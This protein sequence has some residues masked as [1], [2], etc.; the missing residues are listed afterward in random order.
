MRPDTV[1]TGDAT[2]P[3]SS[4]KGRT[5]SVGLNFDLNSM[6]GCGEHRNFFAVLT[7]ALDK[8]PLYAWADQHQY[9]KHMELALTIVSERYFAVNLIHLAERASNHLM[10]LYRLNNRTEMVMAEYAKILTALKNVTEKGITSN[11]AIG[12]FY[13]VCYDGSGL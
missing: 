8:P 2:G 13:R 12:T 7:K 3:Q 11:M 10:K 4:A 1:Q 9:N 6:Q 5:L